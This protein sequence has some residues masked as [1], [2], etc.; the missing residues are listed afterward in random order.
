M[1]AL[2]GG[3]H[4][5]QGPRFACGRRTIK[6]GGPLAADQAPADIGQHVN[7]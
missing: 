4:L 5:W 2:L 1:L 7:A 3:L 6:M